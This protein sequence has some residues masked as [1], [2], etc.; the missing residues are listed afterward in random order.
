M[1]K[2]W[3]PLPPPAWRVLAPAAALCLVCQSLEAG[4]CTL[5]PEPTIVTEIFPEHLRRSDCGLLRHHTYSINTLNWSLTSNPRLES[6][7]ERFNSRRYL[8]L[9]G[10]RVSINLIHSFRKPT[11]AV[12]RGGCSRTT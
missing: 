5:K 7:L 2:S 3:H 6:N 8:I 12:I 1:Y 4:L 11:L 9:C 10:R